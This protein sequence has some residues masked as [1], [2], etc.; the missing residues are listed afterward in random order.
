MTGSLP[1]GLGGDRTRKKSMAQEV[2]LKF[3]IESGGLTM[4]DALPVIGKRLRRAPRGH[5]E[6]A[7]FDARDRCFTNNG[8]A[9][10]L[11]KQNKGK[12]EKT[13]ARIVKVNPFL[14]A[15]RG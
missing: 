1:S 9:L 6:T 15:A 12:A 11:R 3:L 13:F 5:I 2:E 7:Y 14:Q 4:L 8:L 10:R